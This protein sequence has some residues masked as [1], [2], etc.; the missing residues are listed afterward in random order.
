MNQGAGDAGPFTVF[1][2]WPHA[3]DEEVQFAGI[4]AGEDRCAETTPPARFDDVEAVVD[5]NDDV[6]ELDES[7]NRGT[8]DVP[9]P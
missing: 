3:P 7:N 5:V 8:Y 6:A 9:I 1:V 4:P 2:D